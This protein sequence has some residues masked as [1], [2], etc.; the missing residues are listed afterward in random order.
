MHVLTWGTC[1]YVTTCGKGHSAG[2]LK[3]RAEMRGCPGLFCCVQCNH[4]GLKRQ[5]LYTKVLWESEREMW[6]QKQRSGC[7]SWE[8]EEGQE[9]R[10]AGGLLKSEEAKEQSLP[11]SLQREYGPVFLGRRLVTLW[12]PGAVL[13]HRVCGDLCCSSRT[14]THALWVVTTHQN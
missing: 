9:P 2:V 10:E 8:T 7:C 1:E 3:L 13:R 14:W 5:K 4:Q 11:S 6:P 12:P